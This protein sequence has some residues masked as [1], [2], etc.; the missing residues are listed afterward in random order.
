MIYVCIFKKF[1]FIILT[2]N[3]I[4]IIYLFMQLI[5]NN[6]INSFNKNKVIFHIQSLLLSILFL[7]N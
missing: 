7:N 2:L 1:I 6:F 3:I 4:I 5:N